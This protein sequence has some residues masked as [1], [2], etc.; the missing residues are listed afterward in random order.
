MLDDSEML[1]RLAYLY[2]PERA[3]AIGREWESLREHGLGHLADGEASLGKD[4][5]C[6]LGTLCCAFS[7]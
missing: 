6:P 3:D 7:A 5:C 2:G 1:G 4:V